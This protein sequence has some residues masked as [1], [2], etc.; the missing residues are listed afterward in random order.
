MTGLLKLLG[1]AAAGGAAVGVLASKKINQM[2]SGEKARV[3]KKR[4]SVV[5][6][7]VED[8]DPEEL[9]IVV[10]KRSRKQLRERE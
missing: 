9:D 2:L 10:L 6:V 4:V 1:V 7:P 3:S 5:E 8:G